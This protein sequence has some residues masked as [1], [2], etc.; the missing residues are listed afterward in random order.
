MKLL[1]ITLAAA[2]LLSV[3]SIIEASTLIATLMLLAIATL[4]VIAVNRSNRAK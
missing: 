4:F 3:E 1:S 2:A